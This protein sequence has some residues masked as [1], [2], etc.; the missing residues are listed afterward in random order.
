MDGA[1]LVVLKGTKVLLNKDYGC[2]DVEKKL[3]VNPYRTVFRIA[4]IFKVVT[5][6]AI[7]H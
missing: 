5:V 2:S 6:T 4:S 3:L 7:M 1:A